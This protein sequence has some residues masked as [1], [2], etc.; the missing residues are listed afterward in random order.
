MFQAPVFVDAPA[1]DVW[2]PEEEPCD[3]VR[4][5]DFTGADS[6]GAAFASLTVFVLFQFLERGKPEEESWLCK[7]RA[8]RPY[9]P[10]PKPPTEDG[11]IPAHSVKDFGWLQNFSVRQTLSKSNRDALR[12]AAA[13]ANAE[14]ANADTTD[15]SG[16]ISKS[17][18][19]SSDES[20]AEDAPKFDDAHFAEEE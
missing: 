10:K 17:A 7:R 8:F 14:L 6:L 20:P 11:Q 3:Q 19:G 5:S 2:N 18:D 4:F 16:V 12:K 9:K 1:E 15:R 13:D